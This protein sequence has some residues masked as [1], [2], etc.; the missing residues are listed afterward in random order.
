MALTRLDISN[1]RNLEQV[2][3]DSI[4]D[5]FN[6]FY[7]LNGSGKTSLL[8]ALYYLSRGRSFRCSLHSRIINNNAD[9][10]SVFAQVK[11]ENSQTIPVG[12]ERQR[13][14]DIKIRAAGQD[15]TS[16]AE[17]VHLIPALLLNSNSYLLL[18]GGPLFRRKY[19]DWAAFYTMEPFLKVWKQFERILKQRNAVLRNGSSSKELEIWTKELVQCALVMDQLRKEVVENWLPFF[20]DAIA[21]L[22]ALSGLSVRYYPGWEESLSYEAALAASVGRDRELGYTQLG[23]HRADLRLTINRVPVKDILSRGQQKLFVCAM[24]VAQGALLQQRVSR[25]P[26]YLVDDLSSELDIVSRTNLISLLLK[27]NAQVFL[28]S[29][30]REAF[31]E[32]C[33]AP[34]KMF[35][36][37]HGSVKE[38]TV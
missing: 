18:E 30:E 35:H 15:S 22:L 8:E 33:P 2:K 4:V 25:K 24:I 9:R 34:L 14:G 11:P 16:M 1:F 23:P 7:G 37:E 17:L 29:V 21:D 19:L 10:F 5:G 20:Q 36:V 12:I 13:G 26:I 3:I 31:A 38:V 6:V 27:Q 32:C 28:T